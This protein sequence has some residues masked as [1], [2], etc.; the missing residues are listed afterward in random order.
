MALGNNFITGTNPLYMY[1]PNT[2]YGD[3]SQG[4][5]FAYNNGKADT[6]SFI[7]GSQVDG[8]DGA[9]AGTGIFMGDAGLDTITLTGGGWID[10]GGAKDNKMGISG[11]WFSNNLGD[12]ILVTQGVNIKG[13]INKVA[14]TD[15]L[16]GSGS[17]PPAQQPQA[18]IDAG[19][20]NI[21]QY[22]KQFN[23]GIDHFV[24]K[25]EIQKAIDGGAFKDDAVGKKYWQGVV[26]A[27]NMGL[28]KGDLPTAPGN[29]S[30]QGVTSDYLMQAQDKGF[31]FLV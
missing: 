11:E 3:K 7:S 20:D 29:P 6:A 27:I 23:G 12:N 31:N 2:W 18:A 10:H 13:D 8:K 21:E 16:P 14:S 30:L 9:R 26:N 28:L 17:L 19:I 24:T 1:G 5:M 15:A 4:Q 25:D 22:N